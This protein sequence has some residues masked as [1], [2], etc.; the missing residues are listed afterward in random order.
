MHFMVVTNS[1][2]S[3]AIGLGSASS[4]S[5]LCCHNRCRRTFALVNTG[6]RKPRGSYSLAI[7]LSTSRLV[8]DGLIEMDTLNTKRSW[9][10][11]QRLHRQVSVNRERM[12]DVC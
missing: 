11:F 5:S 3:S 7:T 10:G 6:P 12:F 1:F 9:N 4:Q 2:H 8:Y